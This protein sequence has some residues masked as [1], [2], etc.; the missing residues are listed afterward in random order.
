MAFVFPNGRLFAFT[1][2]DDT[3]V[4]TVENVAPVY[5]LLAELGLRATK[6]VWPVPCPEGSR[7]FS[8]S[9]T[10]D[11]PDYLAFVLDLHKQGFE[12]TWHGATM[13]SSTRERTI[14]ALE[15]FHENLGFY[16]QVHANHA[17]NL[18]NLYW[19]TDRV[20]SRFLKLLIRRFAMHGLPPFEGHVPASPFF[21]GD[22]CT[23]HIR[24]ARNLTFNNLN[25]AAINPSLPYH[26]PSRPLVKFWF[27]ASD[28]EGADE[29]I[30]LLCAAQQERLERE[31]GF[32]IVATHFAKGYARDGR[33]HPG[34]R[35]CLERLA[36]R[37]GWFPTVSG[38][39]D[40]LHEQRN[41][42]KLPASEWRKMQW[43]W[44]RDLAIRRWK[45]RRNAKKR[46]PPGR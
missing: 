24:F 41:S 17:S 38:L 21:W 40:H 15:R 32:T 1:I 42:D 12:I 26:D 25:L 36:R 22:L 23:K 30:E 4:A 46:S 34:V 14:R 20:D 2:I 3:D 18:E 37:P 11:D 9:Q 13:E 7:N 43:R 29:F 19:G 35:D 33:V 10:V 27:S 8:S 44:A 45:I 6:T 31:R 28:A 5:R 16:P 39:L